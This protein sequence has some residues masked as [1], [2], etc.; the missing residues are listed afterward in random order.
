MHHVMIQSPLICLLRGEG[1]HVCPS[2]HVQ[3]I[4]NFGENVKVYHSSNFFVC[5]CHI[6][7]EVLG[8]YTQIF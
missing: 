2:I 1:I 7:N 8:E 5:W 4:C 3:A 6:E